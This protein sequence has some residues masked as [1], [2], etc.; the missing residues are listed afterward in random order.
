MAAQL[1]Q[2]EVPGLYRDISSGVLINKNITELTRFK[3]ERERALKQ[4]VIN[5]QVEELTDT[6]E[7]L[8]QLVKS[9]AKNIHGSISE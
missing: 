1:I 2:T 3:S 8:K 7:E 4:E 9:M 6:V 5:K